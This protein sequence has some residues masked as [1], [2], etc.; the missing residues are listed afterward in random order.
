VEG[1]AGR[2]V[3]VTGASSGIGQAIAVRLGHEGAHVAINYLEVE[4]EDARDTARRAEAY[5]ECGEAVRRCGGR[6]SLVR[7][8]VSR[9]EEVE[10]M[11]DT[12]IRELG[13]LDLLVNNAG[14]QMS[15]D[16]HA[17]DVASFDKVLSVNL[18]GAFL[19][20]RALIRHLLERD[21][22]GPRAASA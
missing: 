3:L 15:G 8:D 5:R 2:S 14:V 6:V 11:F 16:S 10:R 17:I 19:C 7:A 20:S 22:P 4:E 9:E 18:R 12:A 1:V 13:G 21:S